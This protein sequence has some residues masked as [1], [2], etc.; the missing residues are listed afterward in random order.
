MS[1]KCFE[2]LSGAQNLG[3][4]ICFQTYD[5]FCPYAYRLPGR[6]SPLLAKDL[7]IEYKYLANTSEWFYIARNK[8]KEKIEAGK[9]VT[10]KQP[11]LIQRFYEPVTNAMTFTSALKK[12]SKVTQT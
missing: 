8:A 3:P 1:E 2:I 6:D 5:L 4:P 7:A 11:L 10:G 12:A 9:M